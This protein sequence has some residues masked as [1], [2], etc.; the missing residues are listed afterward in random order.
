[1][2]WITNAIIGDHDEDG[3]VVEY[4]EQNNEA[5]SILL[6]ELNVQQFSFVEYAQEVNRIMDALSD[7]SMASS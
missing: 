2:G 3:D 7:N 1:M 6:K 4:Y 5:K